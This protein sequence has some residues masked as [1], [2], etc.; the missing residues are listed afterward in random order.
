MERVLWLS[1]HKPT[2]K[3]INELNTKL[4]EGDGCKVIA[5]DKHITYAKEVEELMDEH[6]CTELV[7]VL[8]FTIIAELTEN[9]VYPIKAVMERNVHLDGGATFNFSHFE[10][11]KKVVIEVDEL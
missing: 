8:P 6:H 7:A 2:S 11:I 10:R 9:G 1:R 5:V 4:G 3:Q